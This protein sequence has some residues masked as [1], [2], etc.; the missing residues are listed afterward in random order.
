VVA[1]LA[2]RVNYEVKPAAHT[3]RFVNPRYTVDAITKDILTSVAAARDMI[4][5]TGEFNSEW[6][7]HQ[8]KLSV[9]CRNVLRRR[10]RLAINV[11]FSTAGIVSEC[12]T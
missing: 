4:K 3:L 10:S 2:I 1:H 12:Q 9:I 6:P 11:I 7:D 5:G 8:R